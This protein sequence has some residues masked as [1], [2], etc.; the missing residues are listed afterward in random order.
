[1]FWRGAL[2]GAKVDQT[3]TNQS[4]RRLL[5]RGVCAPLSVLA[6]FGFC[7]NVLHFFFVGPGV[8][9]NGTRVAFRRPLPYMVAPIFFAMTNPLCRFCEP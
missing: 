3:R 7:S 5:D 8:A 4:L 1:L 6:T 2:V 9:P